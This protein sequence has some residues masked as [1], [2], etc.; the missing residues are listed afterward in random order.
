M[1]F[2]PQRPETNPMID[3]SKMEVRV[4]FIKKYTKASK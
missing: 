4:W 2:F 1:N 3:Y